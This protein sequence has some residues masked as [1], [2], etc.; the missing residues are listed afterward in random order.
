MENF[1]RIGV[2]FATPDDVGLPPSMVKAN[3][4]DFGPR[5]GVAWKAVEGKR[6]VVLRGGY[7]IY[8][9]PNPLRNFNARTRSNAPFNANFS[10]SFNSAA[11]TPDGRPNWLLR[12]A[13]TIVAG[14][15]SADAIDVTKPGGVT[16]GGFQT[17]YFDPSQPSTLSHQWNLTLEREILDST[18]LRVGYVGN[19][20]S[21][22]EQ[23]YSYNEAPNNYIWY[24]TTG[25]PLPTGEYS[26]VA[27]RGFDQTSYGAIEVYQ[28]TGWSNFNGAQ[29]EVQRQYKKGYAFQFFYVLS[30][31][32][33]VAGDGWRDDIMQDTN[34]YMPGAVPSDFN[35][36]N[37]FLN[38][39]RDTGIPQHRFRWNWLLD[40]PFGKGK[41][42]GG[43]AAGLAEKLIGGWQIA[44]FGTY[45]SNYWN[46]AT[47]QWGPVGKIEIYGTKYPIEDCRSGRCIPGYLYW[48]G[49]LPANRINSYD[50]SGKPNGV[51]GVPENYKPAITPV[52]PIPANGG[53]SSDPLYAYYESQNVWIPMKDG[54]LQRVAM[55]NNLHP[56]RN[57]VLPGPWNFGLDASIFKTVKIGERVGLRFNVDFFNVLNNPGMVQPGGGQPSGNGILSLQNSATSN[58]PREMQ[59][60]ARVTW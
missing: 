18:V 52:I 46:L 60:T 45:R 43:N 34:V 33:R 2:K 19:H 11:Q 24:A 35:E 40:L 3:Y 29:V 1:T 41:P 22:L 10:K 7:A 37:R 8:T 49:Y 17:S 51:M 28:K 56:W 31:A 9:F 16:R 47:D 36:R 39:R 27:R 5:L 12:S 21:N 53:S 20:A 57:Q 6:P 55:D 4:W 13:P 32:M 14:V 42:V 26:G 50:A 30:N 58:N 44:G 59:F 23:F 54:S 38:Y 48:N 25:L 15:N